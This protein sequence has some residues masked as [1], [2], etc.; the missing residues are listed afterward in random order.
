MAIY[1]IN[2]EKQRPDGRTF[3]NTWY[4][5]AGAPESTFELVNSIADAERNVFG[6][7]IAFTKAHIWQVGAT[8]NEFITI[9]LT[10]YGSFLSTLPCIIEITAK[11]QLFK[12]NTYPSYKAFRCGVNGAEQVGTRWSDNYIGALANFL[13]D[14]T[15]LFP[16]ICDR[17]GQAITQCLVSDQVS[18]H[19]YNKRWYNKA[20]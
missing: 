1:G 18:T 14:I 17:N 4:T 20:S 10:G 19:Q 3:V 13:E 2:V 6:D 15:E 16:E 9:P 11:V 8:P 5:K 12:G 7:K